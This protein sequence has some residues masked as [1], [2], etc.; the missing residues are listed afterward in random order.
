MLFGQGE[1]KY[2]V[3]WKGYE[4]ANE[5]TWEAEEQF[6]Y[7]IPTSRFASYVKQSLMNIF[8]AER[9]EF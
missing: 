9:V 7:E 1:P 6:V 2:Q 3:K 8:T 4:K 5:R